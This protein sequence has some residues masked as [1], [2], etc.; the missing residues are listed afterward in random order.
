MYL[1]YQ[2]GA[3][4]AN[5]NV[6]RDFNPSGVQSSEFEI[7]PREETKF[8]EFIVTNFTIEALALDSYGRLGVL[9]Y[10]KIQNK[11][12]DAET[13]TLTVVRF[14]VRRVRK[15]LNSSRR[16]VRAPGCPAVWRLPRPRMGCISA[17]SKRRWWV[18]LR[19]WGC[20]LKR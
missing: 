9:T 15:S 7:P 20:F 8:H 16:P 17:R 13:E 6:V 19:R 3:N 18:C 10:E 2:I 12:T 14:I 5:T 1:A 4:E 11:L